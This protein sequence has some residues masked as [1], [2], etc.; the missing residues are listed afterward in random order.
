[1]T[2]IQLDSRPC[3]HTRALYDMLVRLSYRS[4]IMAGLDR[5]YGVAISG[6]SPQPELTRPSFKPSRALL[7]VAT[8]HTNSVLVVQI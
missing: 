2:Q 3:G 7:F 4:W 5:N 8:S 1:M 6:L